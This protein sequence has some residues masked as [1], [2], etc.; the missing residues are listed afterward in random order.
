MFP[1]LCLLTQEGK[2]TRGAVDEADGYTQAPA[3]LRPRKE[4]PVATE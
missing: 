2:D 3:T 1:G 4:H